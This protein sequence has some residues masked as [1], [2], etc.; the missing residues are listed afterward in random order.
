MFPNTK[1]NKHTEVGRTY[2][3][4]GGET[5]TN[6]GLKNVKC[7]LSDGTTKQ[8]KFQVGDKITRG[9]LAVS[10]LAASGAGT[11]F[12]PGP[13][14]QSFVVWDKN[15]HVISDETKIP[16]SLNNGT[17]QM[18]IIDSNDGTPAH[19][20]LSG[21]DDD[22]YTPLSPGPGGDVTPVGGDVMPAEGPVGPV[23]GELGDRDLV[24]QNPNE[25]DEVIELQAEQAPVQVIRSPSQPTQA[26]IEHHNACGHVPFRDWCPVCVQTSAPEDSHRN[27]NE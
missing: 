16:M 4:C 21:A 19:A 1:I 27:K 24:N 18:G 22:G 15:A 7:L 14:Y 6:L 26:D 5:V 12:G 23:P 13:E 10:Q 9:L 25:P 20:G 11:W 8:L 3:A 17:Y 2:G